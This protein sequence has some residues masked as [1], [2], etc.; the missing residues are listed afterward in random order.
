MYPSDP[1]FNFFFVLSM[2]VTLTRIE[3]SWSVLWSVDVGW[4]ITRD[5]P[6][7][8]KPDWLSRQ[9]CQP[10]SAAIL[11]FV[12]SASTVLTWS[13]HARH[14]QGKLEKQ[15]ITDRQ[16]EGQATSQ[17]ARQPVSCSAVFVCLSRE[18]HQE[19]QMC[20]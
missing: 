5:V 10:L 16:T 18:T 15:G 19:H 14:N 4:R 6:F 8:D 17:A 11:E 9:N 12:V 20:R 3:V 7:A 13:T 1:G 2:L